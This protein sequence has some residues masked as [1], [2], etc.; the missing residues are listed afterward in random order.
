[1]KA[2]EEF[3]GKAASNPTQQVSEDVEMEDI[4][5]GG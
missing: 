3:H 4:G 2:H 5:G 1:M